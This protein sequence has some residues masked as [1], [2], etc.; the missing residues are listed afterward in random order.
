MGNHEDAVASIAAAVRGFYE[1]REPFRV[2]HGSTYS[3]R[4]SE[5][6]FDKMVDTSKL[7]SILEVDAQSMTVLVEPNVAMDKLVD[8]T[9]PH[10]LIPPVVMEFPGI[11]VGGGFAGTAGESSSFRHGMFEKTVLSIEIVLANGDVVT[12][13]RERNTDLFHG[14]SSSLGTLGILTLLKVELVA[15]KRYVELTY[16][17][18]GGV[19][20]ALERLKDLIKDDSIDYLDGILF[21]P[22]RGIICSGRLMDEARATV[23]RFTRANDPWFYQHAERLNLA[24]QDAVFVESVPLVDYLFRYDRGAFWTGMYSFRYFRVPFNRITRW[25]L[26]GF[27][28]TRIMY[29]ALHQSG[30]SN[31][32]VLQDIAVP[33]AGANELV[34]HIE[35]SIGCYPLWLCPISRGGE[36]LQSN[37][38]LFPNRN[39]NT[40]DGEPIVS[41]G[42]WG[43]GP[44]DR[45]AFVKINRDLEHKI[46]DVGGRKW[47]YAVTYY[48]EDEFW[49]IYHRRDYEALRAKYHASYLPSIYE[50]VKL[51][52]D[53]EQNMV[54]GPW[55]ARLKGVLWSIWPLSG[56]YGVCKAAI[57][58]EYL[59]PR[60]ARNV[61]SHYRKP[62]E[63]RKLF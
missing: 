18:T 32:Y 63:E 8:S 37:F 2:Y 16:H 33:F 9:F 5:R 35:E 55:K 38:G 12:A 27:M 4:P 44:R 11:T 53:A 42:V 23:Q 39:A 58:G 30:H 10:G 15:A 52:L 36:L 49:N 48:T 25:I 17:P 20:G 62:E 54:R 22:D 14:A 1:R 34:R 41:F 13:S 56:L 57:G 47:L 46:Q 6:Q 59:L 24:P 3:T 26:D 50:K 45:R 40:D 31:R 43:P 19:Y 61:E 28:H 7:D 29:H 21:A 51:N 60:K